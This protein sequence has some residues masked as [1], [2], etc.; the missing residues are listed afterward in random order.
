MIVVSIQAS[1][2]ED[3][4]VLSFVYWVS[5]YIHLGVGGWGRWGKAVMVDVVWGQY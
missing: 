1:H 4:W 5:M 3:A 2:V